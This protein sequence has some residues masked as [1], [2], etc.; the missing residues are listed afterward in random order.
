[1]RSATACLECRATK[2]KCVQLDRAKPEDDCVGCRS[3]K[4]YCSKSSR[5]QK[6]Q[7]TASLI[8]PAPCKD[9]SSDFP[10]HEDSHECIELYFR[11]LHERPH[12]LFHEK[13]LWEQ[14]RSGEISTCLLLAI[15]TLGS[16]F[17]TRPDLRVLAATYQ[18]NCRAVFAT[19]LEQISL[20]NIQTA[21]LLANIYAAEQ[22]NDLEAL[23][24]G[25]AN[26][27]AYV[28]RLHQD[29]TGDPPVLREMKCRIWWSLFM[30][31]RWCPPGLGLPREISSAKTE[32]EL[33]MEEVLFQNMNPATNR[34]PP[35]REYGLWHQN[36]L[37]VDTLGPIQDLNLSIVNGDRSKSEVNEE[38]VR[39]T[40]CLQQWNDSLP[41]HMKM[42]NRNLDKYRSKGLGGTHIALHLGYH[43]YCTLLYFHYLDVT[44]QTSAKSRFFAQECWSHAVAFSDLLRCAREK[45]DCHI[46]YMTV[47][48]MTMVSSSVLLHMLL[49]GDES[50]SELGRAGL[51]TNFEMLLELKKYWSCMN[52][53][54]TRLLIFQRACLQLKTYKVDKWLLR[55]LL[56][57][58]LPF[59]QKGS[60]HNAET[61]EDSV[62]AF[63]SQAPLR[64]STSLGQAFEELCS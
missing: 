60:T 24:F 17:S 53:I 59:S 45:N 33:P 19:Q 9:T 8:T 39:L 50:N 25:I 49:F 12:S 40:S 11:F 15:C 38:V 54:T 55:F 6:S 52:A 4:V 64:Q 44:L 22:R 3:R 1:M 48:H 20:P 36:I 10:L 30:A 31:D 46:V 2:R 21:I 26:R 37:L 5:I 62:P 14:F 41:S 7:R 56:E 23:Y 61:N 63:D 58:G 32:R 13:T 35:S 29:Q 34:D 51:L 47:A 28:L 43:H 42:N 16:R 57:H 18:A 27:M